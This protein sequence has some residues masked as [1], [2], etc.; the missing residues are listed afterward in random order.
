MYVVSIVCQA[1]TWVIGL[2]WIANWATSIAFNHLMEIDFVEKKDSLIFHIAMNALVL[3]LM[4]MFSILTVI[5]Y[6]M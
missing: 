4:S 2:F 3:I 1:A 5:F 6:H